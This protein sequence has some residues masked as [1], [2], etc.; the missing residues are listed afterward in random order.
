MIRSPR[1][2]ATACAVIIHAA[3]I[4]AMI[5]HAASPKAAPE[6]PEAI[7]VTLA[8]LAPETKKEVKKPEKKIPPPK[9]EPRKKAQKPR[10]APPEPLPAPV[11]ASTA[12]PVADSRTVPAPE[13]V[14]P[15]PVPESSLS[16]SEKADYYGRL[17]GW[18]DQHKT[19]PREA[20]ARRKEGTAQLYF[21][22]NRDGRVLDYR[23]EQSSGSEMLDRATL[24]M[25]E[26]ANPLPPFPAEMKVSELELVVPVEFFLRHGRRH[27]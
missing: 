22:M 12:E 14:P 25:I 21:R 23:I 3:V 4:T 27:R 1:F 26:S 8:K 6:P 18:L 24:R 13:A 9:P 19:Y 17:L 5:S 10:P 7:K 2:S 15:K 16:P 11:L 20:R